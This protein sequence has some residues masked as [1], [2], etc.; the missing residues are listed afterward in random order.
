MLLSIT[1]KEENWNL[2]LGEIS[3]TWMGGCIIQAEFLKEIREAYKANPQLQLLLLE[4][5]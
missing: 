2:D 1:S 3:R 4:K 5:R